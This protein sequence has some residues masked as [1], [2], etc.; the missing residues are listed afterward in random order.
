MHKSTKMST[1]ASCMCWKHAWTP[2]RHCTC[3]PPLPTRQFCGVAG[4]PAPASAEHGTDAQP[5]T[6]ARG[7]PPAQRGYGRL[8]FPEAVHKTEGSPRREKPGWQL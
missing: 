1:A 5:A 3:S 8:Q 6:G 2:G 4:L 7:A